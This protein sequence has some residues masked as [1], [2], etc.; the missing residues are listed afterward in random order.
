[1]VH[2]IV[3]GDRHLR[4]ACQLMFVFYR[5]TEI[6]AGGHIHWLYYI[7]KG[8][9]HIDRTL[10][11]Q[12]KLGQ[13]GE[14]CAESAFVIYVF[15]RVLIILAYI[16]HQILAGYAEAQGDAVDF[17]KPVDGNKSR[18]D[19]IV[20][21]FAFIQSPVIFRKQELSPYTRY[22]YDKP[23]FY[24]KCEP[25]VYI[26]RQVRIA[27]VVVKIHA[28]ARKTVHAETEGITGVV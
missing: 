10:H 5:R 28:R 1:M 25:S 16:R 3:H 4:V 6:H 17:D 22:V 19:V 8:D 13:K 7:Y 12:M 26:L 15:R 27:A 21:E 24:G 2:Q 9:A 11:A 20:G 14:I 23:V 18:V